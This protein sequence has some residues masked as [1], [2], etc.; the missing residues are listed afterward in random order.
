MTS[1]SEPST[2]EGNQLLSYSLDGPVATITMDDGKANAMSVAMLAQLNQALDQADEDEAVVVLAGREGV[3]SGGYDL[4]MFSGTPEQINDCVRTGGRLVHRLA[5]R[6][7][8]TVAACTGH[9][10]AQGV[11]T[12]LACDSRFGIDSSRFKIGMP[13]VKLGM[14]LPAYAIAIAR[15]R[16]TPSGLT[17]AT[18]TGLSYTPQEAMQV[19]FFTKLVDGSTSDADHVV[20]AA[21]E[22]AAKMAE[23]DMRSYASIKRKVWGRELTAME[24]T[25]TEERVL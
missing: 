24:A 1:K 14:S 22:E 8:P 7:L 12:M 23:V 2:V 20:A 10:M 16:L 18:L 15:L 25:N 17:H 9:A 19:G 6:P 5:S 3:F 4:A 21:Q 13:E 11:F